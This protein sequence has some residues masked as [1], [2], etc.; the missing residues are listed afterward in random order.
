M[1][2]DVGDLPPQ[3]TFVTVDGK[4]RQL[5]DWRGKRV[6]INFWASW[7][8]PCRKEMPLL[9]AA[10]AR[11]RDRNVVVLGLAED[12]AVAVRSSLAGQPVHYPILLADA[13]APGGSLSFG[14]TRRVLPYSVLI[15]EDGRVLRHKIGAFTEE[16]LAE[17]LAP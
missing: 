1:V 2:A 5:S 7:C 4:P 13:D 17:W 10:Y 6:L 14:N 15:G 12:T 16:E 9:D 8:G 3:A 11:Y